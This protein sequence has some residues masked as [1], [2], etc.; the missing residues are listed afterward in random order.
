MT[1]L[2]SEFI[3]RLCRTTVIFGVLLLLVLCEFQSWQLL[4]SY[5]V[6]LVVGLLFVYVT[7]MFVTASVFKS[8]SEKQYR[9]LTALT[10]AK[11]ALLIVALY[12]LTRYNAL[13]P[14]GMIIGLSLAPIVLV[15][16]LI[17]QWHV[18]CKPSGLINSTKKQMGES[19]QGDEAK[20]T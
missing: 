7:G 9:L 19:A 15:L 1:N 13:N 4:L 5:A 20:E 16:K 6:G 10:P 11:Y 8:A 3:A 14:V 2:R 18:E 17:G 12:V